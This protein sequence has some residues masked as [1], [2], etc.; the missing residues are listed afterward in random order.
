MDLGEI[1]NRRSDLS[2][3]LVHLTRDFEG[4]SARD[5]L[6]SIL[7]ERRIKAR[8]VFGHFKLHPEEQGHDLESQ[9]CVCLTETLLEHKG[10]QPCVHEK[11]WSSARCKSS[12]V[13]RYHSRPSVAGQLSQ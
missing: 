6:R 13:C 11:N 4:A 8:T 3:F 5:N 12:L 1:L 9:K 7:K 2:T 10:L